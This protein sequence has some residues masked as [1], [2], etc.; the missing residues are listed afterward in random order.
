MPNIQVTYT[1]VP[2]TKILSAAVNQNFNDVV[3]ILKAHHHD[4]NIYTNAIQ[5]TN[6]GIA[7][8][9]QILDTQLRT[10]ITR[11][12]L[13]NPSSLQP[14][15]V[16]H[17]GLNLASVVAG[18]LPYGAGSN[19][20]GRLPVGLE[21]YVLTVKNSL[22]SWQVI[23]TP[24]VVSFGDGSD[25]SVTFDG[26]TTILGMVPAASVYTMTRDI[27]CTNI[28]INAG[29]TL[30]TNGFQI[31]ASGTLTMVNATT[32]IIQNNGNNGTAGSGA[33]KGTGGTAPAS[34]SVMPGQ[35]GT[36]GGNGS[37]N[38][39]GFSG[40]NG[41]NITNAVL[42][43]MVGGQGGAGGSCVNGS[44]GGGTVGTATLYSGI[45]STLIASMQSN[46]AGT[47]RANTSGTGGGGGGSDSGS[48]TGGGGGG[49]G[50]SGGSVV[51]YA[52]AV[53]GSGT[54]KAI[55]GNGGNGGNATGSVNG[56]GG[57]GGGGGAGGVILIVTKTTSNPFTCTVTGGTHGNGGTQIGGAGAGSNGADGASGTTV[58]LSV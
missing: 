6:S 7:P 37:S 4:P 20:Y 29:V 25:G 12:G 57:G 49:G 14:V 32:S 40:G 22:P 54:I 27:F 39:P 47:L 24:S 45:K 31:F 11:S 16:P 55:G 13:I 41:T 17:G 58:F 9:A 34:Y 46:P 48:G 50:S 15:D 44:G 35:A 56:A 1:Y 10:P 23:P 2:N 18:D 8:N 42:S 19:V 36:D 28:T 38:I 51:I 52:N 5:V 26:S 53:S 43:T 33:T 3:N 30:K 21:N